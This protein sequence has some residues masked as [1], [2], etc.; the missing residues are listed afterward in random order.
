MIAQL[1]A[2]KYDDIGHGL[3]E[4]G[5]HA[6][7]QEQFQKALELGAQVGETFTVD[8]LQVSRYYMCRTVNVSAYCH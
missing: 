6:A 2:I 4:N 1:E 3:E 8:W 7:A 5:S